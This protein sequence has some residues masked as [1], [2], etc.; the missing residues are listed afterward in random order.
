MKAFFL[1]SCVAL[2]PMVQAST[3]TTASQSALEAARELTGAI[4]DLDMSWMVDHMYPP[5]KRLYAN[6]YSMRDDNAGANNAKRFMGT[7]QETEAQAKA[8]TIANERALRASY[9]DMGRKMKQQ[10]VQ[11]ESFVVSPAVSEY[12]LALPKGVESGVRSDKLG[13]TAADELKMGGD[14]S[15]LVILPTTFII[16]VPDTRTGRRVRVEQKSFIYAVRDEV[17]ADGGQSRGTILNKWYFIDGKV[18]AS[19]LRSFF[20]DIPLR[21]RLPMTSSRQL[22]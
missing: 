11:V 6:Q 12:E 16:S 5:L 14:R 20:V 13:K 15:R 4:R 18:K 9:V 1:M 3:P 21:L 17:S 2:A 7:V 10:G 19:E 22:N 8:R